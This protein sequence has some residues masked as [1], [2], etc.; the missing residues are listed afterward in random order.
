[1]HSKAGLTQRALLTRQADMMLSYLGKLFTLSTCLID[2]WRR[3][4]EQWVVKQLP[5]PIGRSWEFYSGVL[6]TRQQSDV[7][8][9][10]RI[11]IKNS[12]LLE[13]YNLHFIV[14]NLLP[15]M[16]FL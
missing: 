7:I 13:Y 4:W 12:K 16:V 8:A 1:M 11:D 5:I 2:N 10:S 9:V 3:A 6:R 14:P 15:Q